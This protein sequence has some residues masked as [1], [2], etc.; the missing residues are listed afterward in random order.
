MG[1]ASR[2][3]E[4]ERFVNCFGALFEK[5]YSTAL[6]GKTF[7][8]TSVDVELGDDSDVAVNLALSGDGRTLHVA[9][10]VSLF[11]A[12][13]GEQAV[14][15]TISDTFPN[16]PLAAKALALWRESTK[17]GVIPVRRSVGDLLGLVKADPPA[18]SQ[19]EAMATV[20]KQS[21]IR[22]IADFITSNWHPVYYGAVPYLDAMKDMEFITDPVINDTGESVVRYFLGNAKSWR[23]P[24]A[25]AVKAELRS[26]LSK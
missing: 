21:S 14:T 24:I 15:E 5:H 16:N 17:V 6:L 8:V 9:L 25:Q 23:G 11:A 10:P 20:L 12:G 1:Q 18:V 13:D 26:R 3:K 19:E 4:C 2:E 22:A 7:M